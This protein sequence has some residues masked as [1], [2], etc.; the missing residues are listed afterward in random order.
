MGQGHLHYNI[1]LTAK[2][3]G[4]SK[5]RLP[6]RESHIEQKWPDFC[7]LISQSLTGEYVERTPSW[8]CNGSESHC[9]WLL[10]DYSRRANTFLKGDPYSESSW[11]L[12]V[13]YFLN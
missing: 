10:C 9:G 12:Q 13:A 1:G 11:L 6:F 7:T 2:S 8:I 3:M 5:Q 4:S